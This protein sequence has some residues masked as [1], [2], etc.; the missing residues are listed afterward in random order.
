MSDIAPSTDLQNYANAQLKKHNIPAI[1]LAI[2]QN[3]EL[4]QVAAGILNLSTGVEAT[5]DSIFQIGSITKVMTTSLIMKLVDNGQVDLDLPVKQ[6]LHDFQMADKEA[7]KTITVRQ[8]LNHTSGLAGDF[9]PDDNHQTGN[10][11]ARYVDRCSL[12]PLI[13]PVGEMYSYSNSA[14]AIAGRIIEV[15]SGIS[16]YQAMEDYLYRPLGMSHAIADPKEMIRYRVAMGH[17]F[18]G[19]NTERWVLPRKAFL[20]LAHAPV[21]ATPAM[22]AADLITFARAHLDKGTA[23]DGKS[24]LSANAVQAMQAPQIQLPRLSQV[25]EKFSGLG[26][27]ITDY[28][29]NQC[30]IIGHSGATHGSLSMLQI[31]PQKKAAFAILINGFRPSALQAITRDCLLTVSDIDNTEPDLADTEPDLDYYAR[32][33]GNYESFDSVIEVSLEDSEL[34]AKFTYKIDPLPSIRLV[35]KPI[36][37]GCFATFTPT[38]ERGKN[39]AFLQENSC[40]IPKYLFSGSRLSNRLSI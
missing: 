1:S 12:L 13:H 14:F 7:T 10:L 29:Q 26:W 8:L 19:E 4:K 36:E 38:G 33:I 35:L 21:G 22:S 31:I 17:I 6:Y 34:L 18:D 30:R 24:W 2:W 28:Q 11:L 3:G 5:T 32:L 16:W 27:G 37:Y 15:V 23:Q 25:F 40:G 39:L 9:F 20:P